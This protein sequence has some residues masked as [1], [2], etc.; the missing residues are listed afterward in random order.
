ME[1]V[2]SQTRVV[3]STLTARREFMSYGV[4]GNGICQGGYVRRSL[5]RPATLVSH[6]VLA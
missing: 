1:F 2:A 6:P 4:R 3:A 5:H